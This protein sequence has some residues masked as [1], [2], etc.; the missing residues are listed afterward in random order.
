MKNQIYIVTHSGN[1]FYSAHNTKESAQLEA[2]KCEDNQL[3]SGNSYP[4]VEVKCVI[5]KN[6]L[7]KI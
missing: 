2:K 6:K 5:I 3:A 4:C 7:W 1:K